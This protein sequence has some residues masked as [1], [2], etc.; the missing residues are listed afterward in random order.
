M[1]RYTAIFKM[2]AISALC[3]LYSCAKDPLYAPDGNGEG[4]ETE[5]VFSLQLPGSSTPTRSLDYNGTEEN[6]IENIDVLVFNS[7]TQAFMYSRQGYNLDPNSGNSTRTFTVSLLPGTCDLVLLTNAR[8]LLAAT[9][10]S[11]ISSGT[12]RAAVEKALTHSMTATQKWNADAGTV[13]YRH[14]PMFGEKKSVDINV[15]TDLTGA[16]GVSLVRMIARVDV[17]VL[18]A[19]TGD[20]KLQGVYVYNTNQAAQ[21]MPTTATNWN[22]AQSRVMA[23]SIPEVS[24]SPIQVTEGPLAY[25]HRANPAVSAEYSGD[26]YLFEAL[27]GSKA[28]YLKNT[29]LVVS[30]IYEN[31]LQY[32]RI[33]FIDKTSG[34][35]VY[36]PILRNNRYY[37]E[38]QSISGP[39]HETPD[40]AFRSL[41]I[42]I[43]ATIVPWN[44]N[45]LTDIYDD[46]QYYFSTSANPIV[47][48]G[49]AGA[50]A[51]QIRTDCPNWKYVL[52]SN[53][54][55]DAAVTAPGWVTITSGHVQ[56]QLYTTSTANIAFSTQRNATGAVRSAYIHIW[57]GRFVI[58]VT[59]RQNPWFIGRVA[60]TPDA[61]TAKSGGEPYTVTIEGF[62]D[63]SDP[64]PIRLRTADGTIID[65]NMVTGV[66]TG[67]LTTG[68]GTLDLLA[69][70]LT[71][72]GSRQLVF[73]YLNP[74]DNNWTQI[75]AP[76][77]A[78]YWIK[79]TT[80]DS[81]INDFT[82]WGSYMNVTVK[83][84]FPSLPIRF[85]N[86]AG[87]A[88]VT[89]GVQKN[90]PATANDL[91]GKTYR[92][93]VPYNDEG[94]PSS[95]TIH[96]QYWDGT[97]NQ[98]QQQ[99][100]T[101]TFSVVQRQGNVVLPQYDWRQ[102]NYGYTQTGNSLGISPARNRVLAH[103]DY[104]KWMGTENGLIKNWYDAMGINRPAGMNTSLSID[105]SVSPG[106][107]LGTKEDKYLVSTYPPE[108]AV[109]C[110]AY[111]ERD[112]G[113]LKW[114]LPTVLEANQIKYMWADLQSPAGFS[115]FD[116]PVNATKSAIYTSTEL[117]DY[118]FFDDFG[119]SSSGMI[120]YIETSVYA[121]APFN[122][123][124]THANK[125]DQGRVTSALL[126]LTNNGPIVGFNENYYYMGYLRKNGAYFSNTNTGLVNTRCVRQW[127][128]ATDVGGPG[129]TPTFAW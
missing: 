58:T 107:A 86:T 113:Q 32:Y 80:T 44:E 28:G 108:V 34:N 100:W 110:G 73:E 1:K 72:A 5:I 59:I 68:T 89:T 74:I 62:Y 120:H 70:W 51:L 96:F 17:S 83:G 122:F 22:Y 12:S 114:M 126:V 102:Y 64:I 21:V 76:Q 31:K 4:G 118:Y 93:Y 63:D 23:P 79:I 88:A 57:S 55:P 26:I 123:T 127:N 119:P 25:T 39:G 2:V 91:T 66:T 106:R 92:V 75:L 9:F 94:N 49:M 10:P 15:N 19:A 30:G 112:F 45:N 90:L 11:G 35:D 24:G 18:A 105:P 116:D 7:T 104:D 14:I 87:T 124:Y 129:Y 125:S 101:P 41:P 61:M 13:G 53:S 82:G 121:G 60:I 54:N 65:E 20:F 42:N 16:N 40:D 69:Y 33:D 71:E 52:S 56:G 6:Y 67:D 97:Y 109:G 99:A 81:D 98:S 103:Q 115:N 117:S 50:D 29:C 8:D 77:Q 128:P 78:A 47:L 46:G 36:L 43:T 3:L 111:Q 38:I 95:R 85:S 84:N 48:Q 37:V 27:G